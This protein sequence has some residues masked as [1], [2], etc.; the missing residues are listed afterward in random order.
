MRQLLQIIF[1]LSIFL[2]SAHA[3]EFKE[4]KIIKLKKDDEKKILVNYGTFSKLFTL[5]WTLYKNGGLVVFHS[6]DKFV[7]QNMLYL[8]YKNKFFKQ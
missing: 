4:V 2:N 1:F 3:I 8:N 6:Y 7:F 5:R